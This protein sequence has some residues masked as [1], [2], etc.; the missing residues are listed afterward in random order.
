M[1]RVQSLSIRR[2]DEILT[3]R[4]VLSTSIWNS[5]LKANYRAENMTDLPPNPQQM[6][7]R[8]KNEGNALFGSGNMYLI[9]TH[10]S[11]PVQERRNS[12]VFRSYSTRS[13]SI[14]V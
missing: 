5:S 1:T 9:P 4:L 10:I 7:E 13:N 14:L 12:Q 11:D 3:T 2:V 8:L 6:A